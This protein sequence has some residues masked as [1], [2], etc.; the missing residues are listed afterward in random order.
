MYKFGKFIGKNR[1]IVL[2][3]AVLLTIPS[4][5]GMVATK[6]N[7]DML[8]YLP[9]DLESVEGQKII[10]NS[11]GSS[12]IAMLVLENVKDYEVSDIVKE[13]EELDGVDSVI[14]LR[15]LVDLE[16]PK[17]MLPKDILDMVY[18]D[19]CTL[20]PINLSESSADDKT[21]KAI[22]DIR[23]IAEE[24]TGKYHLSGIAPLLKD[25]I[26]VADHERG[27]YVLLAVILAVI[28][29]ILTSTSFI[30]PIL[31]LLGIG[32]AV[33]YNMGTN[34]FLGEISYITKAIAAVLQLGVTMDFSIFL[35]HRYE[36]EREKG[37]DKLEAMAI[38]IAN[39]ASSVSGA[40]FT[41]IAGFLA[42]VFMKLGLGKDIG[43][44]MAKGVL[45]GI[46][47]TITILP[48]LIIISDPI[49]NK[50][51]HKEIIPKFDKLAK[52]VTKRPILF[53]IIAIIIA[54][55]AIY[56]QQHTKVY[57]NVDRG[58]PQDMPSIVALNH[59]KE[60]YDMQTTDFIGVKDDLS[61]NEVNEM[62][63]KIEN[64]AGVTTVLA[65][66]KVVGP[67]VP[68][69]AIPDKDKEVFFGNGYQRIF[70]NSS[71]SNAS[72][73]V[74][75]QL[76]EIDNIV[77]EYDEDGFITGEAPLTKDLITISDI[78]FENVNIISI[79]VVFIIIAIVLQSISL[80][81][82]LVA[83]IQLAIFINMG[84]P[85]YTHTVIPFVSSIV[86]GC[87][88]LGSTVDYAILLTTRFKEEL[89]YTTDKRKAMEKALSSS[90]K[91]IVTSAA[92]F[93]AATIGVVFI[94]K[95]DLISSLT[96][97]MA[98]GAII[99]M[100]VILFILP[101][102]LLVLEPVINKTTYNWK[103][104]NNIQEEK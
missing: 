30:I 58:L 88:Q 73:E 68:L 21:L 3:I 41:T 29:L 89:Q 67:M 81:I 23:S 31:F 32:F 100:L 51:K 56:G 54:I 48:S 15:D 7:Y 55:P 43:I 33:I 80:P 5:F 14:W 59:L 28:V 98:R 44:V 8:T 76:E 86:I 79:L 40:A 42:L 71:Y 38:A 70:V 96:S 57:Y 37:I 22:G 101:A 93:F 60:T 50:F 53:I 92:S 95:I 66:T 69:D 64:V 18:R 63:S 27:F 4:I 90:G 82:I 49:I 35:F 104:T 87:T 39:T 61:I 25:M 52:T 26:Q 1:I 99:S 10:D 34:Y 9:K 16:I 75:K 97:M 72:D 17:E 2:I 19:E 47:S 103:K 94:S 11:F 12:E 83:E 65:Y 13:I 77:K 91:S 84:I 102:I 85:T 24:H 78:D 36:E 45:F 6:T 20:V 74:S 46:I 62:V